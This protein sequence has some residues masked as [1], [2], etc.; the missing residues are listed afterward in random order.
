MTRF[1]KIHLRFDRRY[2]AEATAGCR[3]SCSSIQIRKTN[4]LAPNQ[5]LDYHTK[6]QWTSNSLGLKPLVILWLMVEGCHKR[7]PKP[8]MIVELQETLQMIWD[9]LPRRAIDKAVKKYPK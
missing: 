8:K 4:L 9:S 6:D 7:H 1:I 2:K 5:C 3:G